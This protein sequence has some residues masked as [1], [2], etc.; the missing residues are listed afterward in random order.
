[1]DEKE[2]GKAGDESLSIAVMNIVVKMSCINT[3]YNV[4]KFEYVFQVIQEVHGDNISLPQPLH[5]AK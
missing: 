4:T 3:T 2:N 5:R 1:L